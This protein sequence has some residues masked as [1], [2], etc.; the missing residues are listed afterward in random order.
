LGAG[1]LVVGAI[2]ADC[3]GAEQA[4][5]LVNVEAVARVGPWWKDGCILFDST[6]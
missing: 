2:V 3:L 6:G 5:S 1:G 4:H